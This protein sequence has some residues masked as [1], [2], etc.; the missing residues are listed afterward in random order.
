M[1][2]PSWLFLAGFAATG[3]F[4]AAP[5]KLIID[6]DIGGG[7]CNDVDDVVAISIASAFPPAT[8]PN[9]RIPRMCGVRRPFP[10][11]SFLRVTGGH[12]FL[13][14]RLTHLFAHFFW[15][16]NPDFP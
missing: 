3:C 12:T 5:T 4:A 2:A 14:V 6:T 16:L 9:P 1:M 7:G 15:L 10:L 13:D 11:F 8:Q